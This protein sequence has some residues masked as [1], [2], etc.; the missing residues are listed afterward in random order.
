MTI[1]SLQR[2]VSFVLQGEAHALFMKKNW[3][4]IVYVILIVAAI[5]V[6]VFIYLNTQNTV[7]IIPPD[8]LLGSDAVDGAVV[9]YQNLSINS[10][11][12]NDD[13]DYGRKVYIVDHEK[14]LATFLISFTENIEIVR[15]THDQI[16]VYIY[17]TNGFTTPAGGTLLSIDRTDGTIRLDSYGWYI[18]TAPDNSFVVQLNHTQVIENGTEEPDI[19]H[20]NDLSDFG[21]VLSQFLLSTTQGDERTSYAFNAIHISPDSKKIAV[22]ARDI[23]TDQSDMTFAHGV[24]FIF[25][26]TLQRITSVQKFV[27]Q[28]PIQID[29]YNPAQQLFTISVWDGSNQITI[30]DPSG[31]TTFQLTEYQE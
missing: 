30:A 22:V 10:E 3:Q 26:L 27:S 5:M 11:T 13:K 18:A 17:L 1:G 4:Q 2:R 24:V 15:T 29:G 6:G 14:L 31:K 12:K 8:A 19:I 21:S 7:R 9:Y 23:G 25:D 16:D 28:E 20:I